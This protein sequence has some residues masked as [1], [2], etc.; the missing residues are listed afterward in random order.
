[1]TAYDIFTRLEFRRVLFRSQGSSGDSENNSLWLKVLIKDG[2][3]LGFVITPDSNNLVVDFDFWLF[4]P[5]NDC[6]EIGNSIRCSTT[7]PIQAQLAY[8]TTG[9]ND[10]ETD[11]SEGPGPDGN[12]FIQ[13]I[14][15][16]DDQIYYLLV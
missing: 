11:F 8:N 16:E 1:K 10:T 3:T 14:T 7:N 13:W 9:M 2:G 6:S 12:A 15:V 4:G 5:A